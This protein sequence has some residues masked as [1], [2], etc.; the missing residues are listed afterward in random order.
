MLEAFRGE[1]Y[2]TSI[3]DKPA[4]TFILGSKCSD[5]VVLIAD[6]KTIITDNSGMYFDYR[7]K[8]FAELRH[9]VFGSSGSTGNYEQFRGRIR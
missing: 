3:E 2:Q 6:K 5:G 1:S 7:Y 4:M 9:V 8:L